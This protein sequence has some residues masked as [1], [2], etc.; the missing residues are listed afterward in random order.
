MAL[1]NRI[2]AQTG[3]TKFM[4]LDPFGN[5]LLAVHPDEWSPWVIW[6]LS[7][8]SVMTEQVLPEP[9][10]GSLF[11]NKPI[12]PDIKRQ[13]MVQHSPSFIQYGESVILEDLS[14]GS[15]SVPLVI[16]QLGSDKTI[17]NNAPIL[18]LL[19]QDFDPHMEYLSQLQKVVFEVHSAPN[20]YLS[21]EGDQA[22]VQTLQKGDQ[23]FFQSDYNEQPLNQAAL[24]LSVWTIVGIGNIY[25][26]R[27]KRNPVP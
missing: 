12:A 5:K 26:P 3:T 17:I 8:Y 21:V 11:G 15:C 1:Y 6:S 27:C 20:H 19:H 22:I 14:T 2:G 24:A 10:E 7:D 23:S 13:W 9:F 4:T 16:K 18:Q 25:S